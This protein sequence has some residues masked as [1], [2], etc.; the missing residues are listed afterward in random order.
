MHAYAHT[1]VQVTFKHAEQYIMPLG[2]PF[3]STQNYQ[4]FIGH[5]DYV[6]SLADVRSTEQRF[7]GHPS[8]MTG[9]VKQGQPTRISQGKA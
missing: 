4:F 2:N 5:E 1:G 6:Y 7:S 3:V 8:V 9:Q